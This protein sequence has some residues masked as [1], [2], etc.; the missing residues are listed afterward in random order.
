MWHGQDKKVVE[1][2]YRLNF[3]VCL[4]VSCCLDFK[5]QRAVSSEEKLDENE[6]SERDAKNNVMRKCHSDHQNDEDNVKN[7]A[8]AS[9][10][11]FKCFLCSKSGHKNISAK[12]KVE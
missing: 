2:V 12:K 4:Y 5:V 8:S 10:N 3:R 6:I 1:Y 11:D 9:F 7:N